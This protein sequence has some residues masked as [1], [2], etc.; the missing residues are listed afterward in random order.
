MTAATRQP[1]L[2]AGRATELSLAAALAALPLATVAVLLLGGCANDDLA[3]TDPGLERERQSGRDDDDGEGDAEGGQQAQVQGQV[4]G[5]GGTVPGGVLPGGTGQVGTATA[6]GDLGGGVTPVTETVDYPS[7]SFKGRGYTTYKNDDH[8]D[9]EMDTQTTTDPT[10]LVFNT[11]RAKVHCGD[12]DG[13]RQDDV[14]KVVNDR[15]LG[16]TRFT[17]VTKDQVRGALGDAAAEAT[18]WGIFVS[19]VTSRAG[20]VFTASSPFPNYP[21][22]KSEAVYASLTTAT[23][24]TVI[25]ADRYVSNDHDVSADQ[26]D[27]PTLAGI[28]EGQNKARKTFNATITVSKAALGGGLVAVTFELNLPEDRD[29]NLYEQFPVPKRATYTIDTT[30]KNIIKADVTTYANGDKSREPEESRLTHALCSKTLRGQTQSF[31]C[32]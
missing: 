4:P 32:P 18:V 1:N 16:A 27:N 15:S 8:L 23:Y 5:Q 30:A 28:W 9:M 24:S 19:G 6:T 13:C 7:L 29:H 26:L 25:T 21:W 14:D 11:A 17:R 12:L 20:V 10:S 3:R 31:S 22:P 2:S